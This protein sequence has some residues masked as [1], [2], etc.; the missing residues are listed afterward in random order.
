MNPM[1]KKDI[2]NELRTLIYDMLESK[3]HGNNATKEDIH[4]V[5]KE[6]GN[7]TELAEKY[8]DTSRYLISPEIFP[9]YLF[10]LKIVIGATLLGL[11]I[12]SVLELITSSSH[13]WYN[14]IGNWIGDMIGSVGMAFASVTIIFA[15]LEWKG[16]NLKELIPNWEV[17]ELPPIPVKEAIISIGEPI[18]GI[19]FTIIGM[20]IFISAP[21]IM[22]AYYFEGGSLTAIPVFNMD[23]FRVIL[24]LFLITMGLGLLM[25]IWELIDRRYSIPH[26][27]FVFIINT[28][29]TILVVIVF[30]R[31][32]IWN[33]N[34]AIRV[35][36]AFHLGFNSSALSVWEIITKNFVIFLVVI[37]LLETITIIVKTVK[38]NSRFDFMNFIKIMEQKSKI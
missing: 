17:E 4:A 31:F 19:I 33:S 32:D 20:V 8:R 6:L 13:I 18:A 10:I 11:C 23:T 14:Y 26:G 5:L 37:Y 38:Y 27:I 29:S 1:N 25:D 15:V 12:A 7:P 28:I 3:T 22:G 2:E 30:T 34:F 24:P 21:Q 9:L 36:E 16:V 35:N